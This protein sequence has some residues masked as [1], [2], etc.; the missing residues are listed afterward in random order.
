MAILTSDQLVALRQAYSRN[1]V[2]VNIDKPQVNAACQAIEDWFEDNRA[3]LA[4][5][6]NQATSPVVLTPTEK[7]FLVAAFLLQ[8]S[9][10]DA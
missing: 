2:I 8:K 7:R 4:V 3:S 9:G 5:V 6:I 1:N 10:R